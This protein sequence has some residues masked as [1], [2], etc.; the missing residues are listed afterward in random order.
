MN[1]K[2][3]AYTLLKNYNS[4]EKLV[5]DMDRDVRNKAVKSHTITYSLSSGYQSVELLTQN[6]LDLIEKKRLIIACRI[7]VLDT[8]YKM[9]DKESDI[10]KM[11]FFSKN[12]FEEIG[13]KYGVAPSQARR[14]VIKSFKKFY[15][16]ICF[17]SQFDNICNLEFKF[18]KPFSLDYLQ[19]SS[20]QKLIKMGM[21]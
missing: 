20:N 9:T 13:N 15:E 7:L 8:L 10:L 4:Y 16:R 12:T 5:E 3:I 17:D 14:D 2:A 6:I 18:Y 1:R 11:K 19:C 21:A